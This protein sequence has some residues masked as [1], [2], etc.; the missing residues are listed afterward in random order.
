[1]TPEATSSNPDDGLDRTLETRPGDEPPPRRERRDIELIHGSRPRMAS[2]IQGILLTRLRG[3]ALLLMGAYGLF[4]IRAVLT[5][6]TDDPVWGESELIYY[7]RFVVF[8]V[9]IG[10]SIVLWSTS[11]FSLRAL[12]RIEV[13]VFGTTFVLAVMIQQRLIEQASISES[14]RSVQTAVL[15]NLLMW[16][17]IVVIYGTFIPNNWQRAALVLGLFSVVPVVGLAWARWHYTDL[18]EL[19]L[20]DYFSATVVMMLVGFATAVYG[21]Y[22]I[23]ALRRQA[24]R[25]RRLGQYRLTKHLGS[26]GMGEVYL[27]EHQMLKRPCAIKTISTSRDRDP[28][29]LARFER[30]V[31]ATA[32]L[33][34]WNTV[35]I[36]DYGQAED[37]TLYYVMEYLPGL[38]LQEIVQRQGP[39]QPARAVHL[40]LQVCGAL[41]EAHSFGLIHRDLKPSNVLCTHRG[42]TYDIAKLLDF[43]LVTSISE[44]VAR[45]DTVEGVHPGAAGSPHYMAPE[46][47]GGATPS[48][49]SDIYSLAALLY[50]MVVGRPPFSGDN[51]L[52]VMR[53]H[54][55]ETPLPLEQI[56]ADVPRDLQQV[57]MRGLAKDP[58]Q[59]FADVD[60]FEAALSECT[61][62]N[63]WSKQQAAQWWVARDTNETSAAPT[64]WASSTSVQ[65]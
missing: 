30:E 4:I 24:F 53:A 62:A 61:C 60:E 18:R 48:V 41:E 15:G 10:C 6:P 56:Q 23:G 65:T 25:A 47:C 44:E 7:S 26:G 58:T 3:A 45:E 17:A 32:Q 16:F 12:R 55:E 21:S 14:V 57:V 11:S 19:L 13:V 34:H 49:R 51:P 38:S 50:F 31:R 29:T 52:E 54:V 1:M 46:V 39:M 5:P 59:R 2:E 64:R 43:G 27:A 35:E 33:T 40:M 9:L 37:G 20:T 28:K 42:G 8:A 63:Q 36:F 22:T